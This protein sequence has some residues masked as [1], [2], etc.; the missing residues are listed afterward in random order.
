MRLIFMG[1]LGGTTVVGRIIVSGRTTVILSAAKD[2][3]AKEWGALGE[4]SSAGKSSS[5]RL[6]GL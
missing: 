3:A 5:L 1:F 4:R 6:T 2:L